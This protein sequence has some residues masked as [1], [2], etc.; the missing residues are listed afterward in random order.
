LRT[1][2]HI[3]ARAALAVTVAT[4]IA[5][6]PVSRDV[7]LAATA[8]LPG[9]DEPLKLKALDIVGNQQVPTADILAAL[10]FHQGDMVS[11][12]QVS[13]GVKAVMGVYHQKNVGLKFSQMTKYAGKSMHVKW[14]IVE[15]A[16]EAP[17][18]VQVSLVVDKIVFEGNKSI[19]TAD[20]TAAT[21]LRP[22][23]PVNQAGLVADQ[24][25]IQALYQKRDIGVGIRVVPTQPQGDNHVVLTY[26]ITE[27]D[28]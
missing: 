6:L 2:H 13:A 10:P 4:G 12:N 25:A 24:T 16:P 8:A 17:E 7:A 14:T 18:T 9:P 20:L 21:K 5:S 15:Q 22:G 27:K 28:D 11:R 3:L 1:T 26:Q 19:S 23:S